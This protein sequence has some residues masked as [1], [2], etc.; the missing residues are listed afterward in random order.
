MPNLLTDTDYS[1]VRVICPISIML[2]ITGLLTAIFRA[3]EDA[4]F[5]LKRLHQIP[6]DRCLYFTG[7]HHLKCTV[8]PYK[9][10]TE[11]AISCKDFQSAFAPAQCCLRSCSFKEK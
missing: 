10:F 4:H 9:A 5:R 11:D 3:I 8:N 7:C 6:C 2:L 1:I